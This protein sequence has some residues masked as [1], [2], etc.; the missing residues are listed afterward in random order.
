[1]LVWRRRAGKSSGSS[2]KVVQLTSESCSFSENSEKYAFCVMNAM[3]AMQCPT[4]DWVVLF[5]HAHTFILKSEPLDTIL[6]WS[7][8][9][10]CPAGEW[11]GIWSGAGVAGYADCA[12]VRQTGRQTG[13][14]GLMGLEG[15]RLNQGSRVH[16]AF[17]GVQ[18]G[19]EAHVPVL[20]GLQS[21]HSLLQLVRVGTA[22]LLELCCT[23]N[24]RL[25]QFK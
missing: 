24:T 16:Q 22:R 9:Q 1:M 8:V 2:H 12:P 5:E 6:K 10:V 20:V 17:V 14:W 18:A 15:R 25:S 23:Q 4:R 13:R 19:K 11:S 21:H 3:C 7:L